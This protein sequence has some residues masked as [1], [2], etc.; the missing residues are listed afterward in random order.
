MLKHKSEF[1][2]ISF[3]TEPISWYLI[4]QSFHLPCNVHGRGITYEKEHWWNDTDWKN[5]E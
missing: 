1:P 5:L 2:E 3:T 4:E